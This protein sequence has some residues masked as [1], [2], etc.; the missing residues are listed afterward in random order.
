VVTGRFRCIAAAR[1]A[2]AKVSNVPYI[3]HPILGFGRRRCSVCC[4]SLPTFELTVSVTL[5][6]FGQARGLA[7][8]GR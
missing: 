2:E 7:T 5:Q 8:S 3:S 1:D 4:R 6:S